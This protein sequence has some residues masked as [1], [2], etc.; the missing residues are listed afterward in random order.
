MKRSS[1]QITIIYLLVGITWIWVSDAISTPEIFADPATF[2]SVKGIGYV[3]VTGLLMFVYLRKNE[4]DNI[5]AAERS[6]E[7]NLK[8][9][10]QLEENNARITDM[11]ES[12]NDGF[13]ALDENWTIT[14]WNKEAERILSIPRESVVGH[15]FWVRFPNMSSFKFRNYYLKAAE[16]QK[17]YRFK[18]Y[19]ET[20]NMWLE[21]TVC[22][23]E[24]GLSIFFHDITQIKFLNK[25]RKKRMAELA[26]T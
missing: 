11:L 10:A 26:T 21:F 15:N 2:Q 18:E 6:V 14:Y 1:A 13:I 8:H 22:P 24:K 12:V 20:R 23:S 9:S 7:A 19:F 4:D 16:D 25:E 5:E 3:I 17:S